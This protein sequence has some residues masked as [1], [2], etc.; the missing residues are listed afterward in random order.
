MADAVATQPSR[1]AAVRSIL[2]RHGPAHHLLPFVQA[3]SIEMIDALCLD[4]DDFLVDLCCGK[5][6]FSIGILDQVEL[7]HQ[8][9][10]VDPS[11]TTLACIPIR[12]EIRTFAMDALSFS[13]YPIRC[14]KIL[15]KDGIAAIDVRER[16]PLFA[17]LRNRLLE[18]GILLLANT[19]PH[20]DLPLFD[21]ALKRLHAEYARPDE[22][23]A[24]L[25]RAGF[26]VHRSC[27][28][29]EHRMPLD[30]YCRLVEQRF[31]PVLASFSDREIRN[32]I[33]EIRRNHP[34]R[35][36]VAYT[37]RIDLLAASR[38]TRAVHVV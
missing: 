11:P 24:Q 13:A 16:A 30:R 2:P 15:L 26:Q 7:R 28:E 25:H 9:L 27:F 8:V 3:L 36:P 4:S 5:S 34:R 38:S 29:Y 37:D 12:A 10:V 17:G 14:D 21:R 6:Y 1:L 19:V 22:L 31:L 23:T 32:G 35:N 18:D 33:G 20:R